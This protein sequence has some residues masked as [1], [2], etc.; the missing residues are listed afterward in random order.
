MTLDVRTLGFRVLL[1]LAVY[2]PV[3]DFILRWLPG[4]TAVLAIVRQFPDALVWVVALAA[5]ALHLAERGTLRVIGGRTDRWLLAFLGV[6]AIGAYLNSTDGFVLF[7]TLKVFL[8]YVPLIY[9]LIMLAPRTEDLD[10]VQRAMLWAIGIQAVI[11]LLELVVGLPAKQFFSVIRS[12]GTVPAGTTLEFFRESEY[13]D[14][15]GTMP[16]SVAYA[17]F[18]LVGLMVWVDAFLRR[19]VLYW[20]GVVLAVVLTFGS[21]SRLA[22]LSCVVIVLLHQT[23]VRGLRQVALAGVVALPLAVVVVMSYGQQAIDQF[24]VFD[25]FTE[26]YVENAK[27][28]RLSLLL[29]IVPYAFDGGVKLFGYSA[30]VSIVSQ[31]IAQHFELPAVFTIAVEIVLED[32]YW[33]ALLLYYGFIGLGCLLLFFGKLTL[34]QWRL[35]KRPPDTRTYHFAVVALLLMV[36]AIPFNFVNQA[37]EI[38][39]YSY[40][41]WFYVGLALASALRALPPRPESAPAVRA[42]TVDGAEGSP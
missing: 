2:L 14:V 4:P 30:D 18:M 10:K 17:Y 26:E 1:G 7:A 8:R 35:V 36:M 27:T 23:T 21:G 9:A 20:L 34:I 39:Q 24:Y 12:D 22:V 15:T 13:H 37:F 42:R 40:Y 41:Q 32:V 33:V 6:V 31:A 28:Q 5:T 38:R 19:P 11:G 29:S 25:V 16:R 3:E